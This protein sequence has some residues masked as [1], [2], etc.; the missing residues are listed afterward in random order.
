M[1]KLQQLI[2][3]VDGIDATGPDY[4]AIREAQRLAHELG[5]EAGK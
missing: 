3:L 1:T 5:E 2:Q 4:Q